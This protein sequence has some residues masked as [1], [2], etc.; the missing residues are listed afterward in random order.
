[1]MINR[2][3]YPFVPNLVSNLQT[4]ICDELFLSNYAG[5]CGINAISF[6]V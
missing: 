2:F 4:K 3:N 6:P 1:M 5:T